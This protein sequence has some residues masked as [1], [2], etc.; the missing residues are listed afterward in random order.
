IFEAAIRRRKA[1]DIKVGA[2]GIREVEFAAQ[3]FQMVRGG[4][5][6]ALRTTS[7]RAALQVI[8]ER[9]LVEPARAAALLEAYGFLR[10][11]EHRLQYYDDQQTQ[12][13]PRAPEHRAAIAE[14]MDAPDWD[15]LMRQLDAHRERVQEAFNA[16]FE[17]PPTHA[18]A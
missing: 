10:R 11:L 14:A 3:L 18:G 4:R 1:D 7:T 6:A 9:G 17:A 8:G 2:G 12:A 15:A 13:L 5:D 16:L